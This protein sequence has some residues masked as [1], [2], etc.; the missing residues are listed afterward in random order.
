M[1]R[2]QD[3]WPVRPSPVFRREALC[4]RGPVISRWSKTR[5]LVENHLSLP[6]RLVIGPGY[7]QGAHRLFG[8]LENGNTVFG[9]NGDRLGDGIRGVD[10][11][12]L[13]VMFAHLLKFEQA[14]DH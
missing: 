6:E 7:G 3:E 5:C 2:L 14:I 8:G 13:V 12:G 11:R 9:A 10:R 1:L 4:P